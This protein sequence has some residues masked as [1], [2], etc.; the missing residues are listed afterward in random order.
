MIVAITASFDPATA[1][2][3]NGSNGGP[4]ITSQGHPIEFVHK[5]QEIIFYIGDHDG[6]PLPT[7]DMTGRATIQQGGK[8]VTVQLKST[9]P[10]VMVGKAEAEL[11]PQAR[12]V[13]S[14]NLHGHSLTA[15]FTVSC[16]CL[17]K[18]SQ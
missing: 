12:V 15:R 4:I 6:S 1:L 14:A 3:K 13:F 8:T 7:N 17:E 9:S 2:A 10:N 18:L 16:A 11:A 5:G